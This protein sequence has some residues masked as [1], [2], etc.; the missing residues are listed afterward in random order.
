MIPNFFAGSYMP[1]ASGAGLGGWADVLN[2]ALGGGLQLASQ[3]V[4]QRPSQLPIP[5]P[6]G[7]ITLPG[8]VP[9]GSVQVPGLFQTRERAVAQPFEVMN[10]VTGRL[11]Y[12]A[13][14]GRPVLFSGDYAACRRVRH[15]AGAAA[16]HCGGARR[17]RFR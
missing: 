6:L 16:K 1:G 15:V 2:T 17:R 12:Y 3:L 11:V 7:G 14:R 5:G 8:Y 10:P 4:G 9:E 13:P